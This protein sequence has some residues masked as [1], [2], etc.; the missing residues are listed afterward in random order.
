MPMRAKSSLMRS[1][2]FSRAKLFSPWLGHADARQVSDLTENGP[3]KPKRSMTAKAATIEC[4][5]LETLRFG[6]GRPR[7]VGDLP[8]ISMAEP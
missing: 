2:Q 8:R 5:G 6:A 4:A 3:I 7:Q 1:D